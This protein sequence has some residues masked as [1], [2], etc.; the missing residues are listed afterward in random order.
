MN[1]NTRK[2]HPFSIQTIHHCMHIHIF[3]RL[4]SL[5]ILWRCK[6]LVCMHIVHVH[7]YVPALVMLYTEGM[8]VIG[9]HCLCVNP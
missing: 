1:A 5:R 6:N 8:V 3:S 2:D 7:I 4:T 9:W